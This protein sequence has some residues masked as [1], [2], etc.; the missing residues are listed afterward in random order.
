MERGE[1][2]L[3]GVIT[4]VEGLCSLGA[5]K[6]QSTYLGSDLLRPIIAL[7]KS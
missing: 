5:I 2:G 4:S 6:I 7:P 3:V 1:S